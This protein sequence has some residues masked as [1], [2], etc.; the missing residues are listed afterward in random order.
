MF[1]PTLVYRIRD[2]E[3]HFETRGS[4]R[5]QRPLAKISLSTSLEGLVLRRL[6]S[7]PQGAAAY[8]VWVLLLQ[9]AA[10]MPCRGVLA[11]ATGAYTPSDLA[12]LTGLPELQVQAALELL[13]SPRIGLLELLPLELALATLADTLLT[14]RPPFETG[15]AA[16]EPATTTAAETPP[17][18]QPD[19]DQ[20]TRLPSA[21][22]PMPPPM[23]PPV[24]STAAPVTI[25]PITGQRLPDRVPSETFKVPKFEEFQKLTREFNSPAQHPRPV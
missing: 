2:W 24:P 11:D 16:A 21:V 6:L 20:S 8:G 13:G 18:P 22:P 12:L 23:P 1:H 7:D 10:K 25:Q 19:R 5:H 17:S 3:Q 4:R 15:N 9:I 14:I